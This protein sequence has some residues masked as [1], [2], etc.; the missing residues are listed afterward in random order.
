M[1][2]RIQLIPLMRIRIWIMPFN[3][4]RIYADPDPQH[5][6]IGSYKVCMYITISGNIYL[7]DQMFAYFSIYVFRLKRT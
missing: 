3:L 7:F 2:I 4:M 1:R 6:C 5:C